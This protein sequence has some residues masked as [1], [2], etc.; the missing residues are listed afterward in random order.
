MTPSL[1]IG[2]AEALLAHLPPSLNDTDEQVLALAEVQAR[3]TLAIAQLLNNVVGALAVLAVC[4]VLL[5]I[6]ILLRG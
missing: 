3:S 6:L 1:H 4:A 2:Q 5:S